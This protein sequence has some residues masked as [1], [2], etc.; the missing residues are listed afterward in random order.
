MLRKIVEERN[1][2]TRKRVLEYDDV[3]NEQRRVIYKYRRQI[4][5][6]RD[7]SEIAHEEIN[8]VIERLVDK[9]TSGDEL[10]DWNLPE[11]ERQ[12]RQLWPMSVTVATLNP[13]TAD[14]E[15]L[16]ESLNADAMSVYERRETAAGAR[17][18]RVVWSERCS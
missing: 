3:L 17:R 15:K 13:A 11:L 7:M 8:G 12:L 9:Y 2:L 16:T 6:G 5:E 18:R 1:F 10:E 14:R 4:L